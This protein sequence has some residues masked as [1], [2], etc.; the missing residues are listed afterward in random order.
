LAYAINFTA[1]RHLRRNFSFG[2]LN[3]VFFSLFGAL[4]DPSLVLSWFVSQ[5]TTSNFLI[6]LIMPIQNGGWF[7]PQLVMSGC[8]QSRREKSPFTLSN[9]LK[10]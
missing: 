2:V 1:Q 3:G 9:G 6:G 10:E 5:L 4:L 7:L 8:L